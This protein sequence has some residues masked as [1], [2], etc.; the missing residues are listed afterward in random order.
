MSATRESVELPPIVVRLQAGAS[1]SAASP[2]KQMPLR[3]E[4]GKEAYSGGSILGVNRENNFV[5]INLGRIAGLEVGNTLQVYRGTRA[6]ATIEVIQVRESIAAC[7]IKEEVS[8]PEA[9][10]TV[11]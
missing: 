4:K 11:R 5:V 2:D 9:G 7:N 10:D 6:I 8:S 1:S 3:E